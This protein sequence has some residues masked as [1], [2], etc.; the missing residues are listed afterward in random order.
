[1]LCKT[2]R[3]GLDRRYTNFNYYCYYYYYCW[4]RK[5]ETNAPE[6]DGKW[7]SLLTLS[8][9]GFSRVFGLRVGSS[10]SHARKTLWYPGNLRSGSIFVSLWKLHSGKC[11]RTAQIGPDLR[12]VP[13]VPPSRLDPSSVES[14]QAS[15]RHEKLSSIVWTATVQ[16][17]TSRS[18]TSN[19]VQERLTKRVL[20]T[21]SQS[22]LLNIYFRLNRV[23][24]WLLSINVRYGPNA[25]SHCTEAW[26]QNYPLCD[27]PL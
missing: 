25:C 11:M 21:K 15:C 16:N 27:A 22:Y 20:W 17:W 9:I 7:S 2:P 6:E 8:T 18:H 26:H 19:I 3:A 23:Q 1:M 4:V 14:C 12:L 10:L 13:W 24:S 5:K